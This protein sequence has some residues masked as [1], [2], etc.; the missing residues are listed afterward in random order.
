MEVIKVFQVVSLL[1]IFNHDFVCI[2]C[3]S[4]VWY[5]LFPPD[6]QLF[7]EESKLS[8]RNTLNQNLLNT[9]GNESYINIT[10]N[11]RQ[12]ISITFKTYIFS[13]KDKRSKIC[14]SISRK[15]MRRN[16]LYFSECFLRSRTGFRLDRRILKVAITV[17]S[18]HDCEIE[19]AKEG[20]FICNTFSFR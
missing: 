14:C 6:P 19:C 1:Q 20:H 13:L 17:P 18:L 10:Y 8:K 2:S 16:L 3:L 7:F 4:H 9:L 5:I 15:K 12:I 11:R